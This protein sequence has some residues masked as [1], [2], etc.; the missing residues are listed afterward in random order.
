M[1]LH[2]RPSHVSDVQIDQ[3]HLIFVIWLSFLK[4]KRVSIYANSEDDTAF[5]NLS[6]VFTGPGHRFSVQLV[7]QYMS[8]IRAFCQ[9]NENAGQEKERI[10]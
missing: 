3:I 4:S 1:V 6:K 2:S 5:T 9:L 7:N 10:R 8:L